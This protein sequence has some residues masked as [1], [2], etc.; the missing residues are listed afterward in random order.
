MKD[1]FLAYMLI[2][3]ALLLHGLF[4]LQPDAVEAVGTEL[5]IASGEAYL[6]LPNVMGENAGPFLTGL[7][8]IPASVSQNS[9]LDATAILQRYRGAQPTQWG[10]RVDGVKTAL[11]TD[12]ALIALTLDACGGPGSDGY[13]R[14]LI[15][16]LISQRIP[17]TL[18]INSRWIEANPQV[19]AE[20]ASNPLFEIEN[21]G[22]VHRPLSVNGRSVYGIQG[23]GSV[24][25]VIEEILGNDGEI[26]ELTGRKPAFFRPGTAYCDEVAV[27]IAN[28]LEYQIVGY[29]VLGDAGATFSQEQIRVSCLEAVPGSIILCHM[30]H[31]EKSTAEGLAEAIPL[32][33]ERGF[34]FVKL[35]DYPLK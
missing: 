32:L 33:M 17:A 6:T 9:T 12:Q 7:D 10:E 35:Q 15:Q 31:P 21:H 18:F 27:Q 29:S 20:L 3:T 5:N 1:G 25:E 23:T 4:S 11:D 16:Y 24:T 19:F 26:R 13:D 2:G 8:V 28:E 30:N 22:T 34:Q 14:D